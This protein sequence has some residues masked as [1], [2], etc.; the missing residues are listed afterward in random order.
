MAKPTTLRI[1]QATKEAIDAIVRVTRRDFSRV[2]NEMLE[3]AVRM[4]RIP[5][6]V[7]V[8]GVSGRRARVA[9]TGID[10]FEVALTLEGADGDTA[11]LGEAF[12][13]LTPHQLK[14]A[15]AYLSAYPEEI[16]QRKEI[17]RQWESPEQVWDSFP[18]TRCSS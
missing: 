18:F 12:P 1:P 6:V 10:V 8:D 15:L 2:A 3:E 14:V 16:E 4:R 5:G 9:G 7:F 13:G 17:E 11:V